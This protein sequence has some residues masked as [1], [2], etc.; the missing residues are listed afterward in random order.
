MKKLL[1]GIAIAASALSVNAQDF[2][3]Y[4]KVVYNGKEVAN[5]ETL[6]ILPTNKPTATTSSYFPDIYLQNLEEDPRQVQGS[7]LFVNPT[8]SYYYEHQDDENYPYGFPSLCFA[9]GLAENLTTPAN[10]CLTE[11]PGLNAGSGAVIVPEAGKNTFE[12]QIHLED[13]FDS[14]KTEMKLVMYAQDDYGV[15]GQDCSDAFTVYLVFSTTDASVSNVG[16]DLSAPAEYY[17]LQGRKVLNPAKGL[18]IV[19]QNGKVQKSLIR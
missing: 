8:V 15:Y 1:L 9:G 13:A 18:Y 10:S 4:F 14:A 16:V 5:G 11:S 19:K 3:D 6:Y 7:F 17:D 2:T 12:W